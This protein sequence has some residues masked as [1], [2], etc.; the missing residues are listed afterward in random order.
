M[1]FYSWTNSEFNW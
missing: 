1:T